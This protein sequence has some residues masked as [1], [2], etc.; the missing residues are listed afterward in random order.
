MCLAKRAFMSRVVNASREKR[1]ELSHESSRPVRPRT[2]LDQ[3]IAAM[4]RMTVTQLRDKYLEVFGE[5]SRS[6][7]KDFLFKRI[8]W[9]IQSL[10]EGTLVGAGHAAGPRNWPATPTCGSRCRARPRPQADAPSRSVTLPA[11]KVT[12][13]DR[14]PIPGTVLTRKYRG[15]QIEVKVLPK[16]SSTRAR[17][18]ARCRR[19][20][21]P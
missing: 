3:T 4:G 5:P 14:L 2:A 21:R 1:K 18:T 6:G 15:R 20:P 11:P 9:R 7:N 19:W 17:S 13:H 10:A 16:A 12:A 8:V